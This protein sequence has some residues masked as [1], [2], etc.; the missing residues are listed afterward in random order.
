MQYVR[1]EARLLEAAKPDNKDY[2]VLTCFTFPEKLYILLNNDKSGSVE[3]FLNGRAFRI[4]NVKVFTS[5]VIPKY[6]KQTSFRSFT[7]QINAYNFEKVSHKISKFSYIHEFFQKENPKLLYSIIRRKDCSGN[8]SQTLHN[9]LTGLP[10]QPLPSPTSS[11]SS[12]SSSISSID[13]NSPKMPNRKRKYFEEFMLSSKKSVGEDSSKVSRASGNQ[14]MESFED[15]HQALV[16]ANDFLV[17]DE[18]RLLNELLFDDNDDNQ[19]T[20]CL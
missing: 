8:H 18:I 2:S 5:K 14:I 9:R 13:D 16:A 1:N 11:F 17:D 12:K 7:R 10:Q 3:W 15:K 20:N 19:L 4:L 6:F